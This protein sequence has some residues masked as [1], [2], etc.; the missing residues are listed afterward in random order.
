MAA[1]GMEAGAAAGVGVPLSGSALG[2]GTVGAGVIPTRTIPDRITTR[3][4]RSWR[5]VGHAYGF[6]ATDTGHTA[7]RG[8]AGKRKPA[9]RRAF[10]V[11]F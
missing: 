5:A 1:I 11:S 10:R 2:S 9:A 3:L 6:G 8:A 7:G 4:L